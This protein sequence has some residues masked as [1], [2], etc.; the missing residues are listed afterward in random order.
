LDVKF[1]KGPVPTAWLAQAHAL[2]GKALAVGLCAWFL[3]GLKLRKEGLR[4]TTKALERFGVTDRAAKGRA[5][6]ALGGAGLLRGSRATG[7]TPAVGILGGDAG[8]MF[9][10]GP[11][12]LPWLGQ[13]CLLGGSKVLAVALAVW[14][15][16]GLRGRTEGLELA[17]RALDELGGVS[18]P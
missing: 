4:L 1:L 9:I 16:A 15:Q 8:G 6:A 5:V 10:Q 11:I 12:P 2:P 13:A 18:R 14:L 7:R 3:A 17:T